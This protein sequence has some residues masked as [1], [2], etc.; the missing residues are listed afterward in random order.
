MFL[1]FE[2]CPY[3][4]GS[5]ETAT[6]CW[7]PWHRGVIVHQESPRDRARCGTAI[8]DPPNQ[9]SIRL[10]FVS[11]HRCHFEWFAQS[12]EAATPGLGLAFRL[13][14]QLIE[15]Q[16][17]RSVAQVQAIEAQAKTIGT[18]Q[19]TLEEQRNVVQEATRAVEATKEKI[20]R[21]TVE[22]DRLAE[23]IHYMRNDYSPLGARGCA[24]CVY[25]NGRFIRACAVH[26]WYEEVL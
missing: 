19:E 22:R 2:S 17:E 14:K 18:L 15:K 16:N 13:A 4:N 5:L 20:D 6:D 1:P 21:V 8:D 24:L 12:A 7:N 11:C 10:D 23:I 25:D 9:L 26:R 3:C